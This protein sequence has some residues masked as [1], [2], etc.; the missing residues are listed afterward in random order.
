M[1]VEDLSYYV[2]ECCLAEHAKCGRTVKMAHPQLNIVSELPLLA[3][4]AHGSR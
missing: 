4:I 3:N 1:V 2:N